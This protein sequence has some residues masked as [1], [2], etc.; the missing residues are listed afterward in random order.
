ML[1][2]NNGYVLAELLMSLSIFL[3]I[4]LFFIPLVIDLNRQSQELQIKKQ[5]TEFLYEE[6]QGLLMNRQPSAD[7]TVVVNGIEYKISW[8]NTGVSGE[9]EVCVKVEKGH[10][11]PGTEICGISE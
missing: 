8:R 11:L 4:S 10:F 6:L 5:A 2:K 9:K 7:H 1:W 3:M